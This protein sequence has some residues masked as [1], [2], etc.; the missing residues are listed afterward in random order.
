MPVCAPKLA[1]R[2]AVRPH[3]EGASLLRARPFAGRLAVLADGGRRPAPHHR[4][5]L[6]FQLLRPR[7][8]GRSSTGS[9]RQGTP[10]SDRRRPRRPA[11]LVA[12]LRTLCAKGM[13]WYLLYAA[14]GRPARTS[15]PSA[16][17]FSAPPYPEKCRPP[18]A[19][20]RT[21]TK[22]QTKNTAEHVNAF[23]WRVAGFVSFPWFNGEL[24]HE[25]CPLSELASKPSMCEF[26]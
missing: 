12:P 5:R 20:R 24:P 14:P 22:P 13:R 10:L 3:L 26:P 8:A 19:L 1:C 4:P 9:G 25:M 21:S 7:P 17:G 15:P 6:E 2:E 23:T 16:A 18:A 11:R